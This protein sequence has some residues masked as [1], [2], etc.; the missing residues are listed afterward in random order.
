MET[1]YIVGNIE[2][3][4]T[5]TGEFRTLE[6]MKNYGDYCEII[7]SQDDEARAALREVM[8]YE[9]GYESKAVLN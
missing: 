6:I 7:S 9:N 3:R 8:N 5:G 2:V 4:K 1:N